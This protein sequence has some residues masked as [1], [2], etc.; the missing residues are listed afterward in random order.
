MSEKEERKVAFLAQMVLFQTFNELKAFH[1]K[2]FFHELGQRFLSSM[3][4]V[5]NLFWLVEPLQ[6]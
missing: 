1:K 4:V 3:A 2:D 6:L 5:L